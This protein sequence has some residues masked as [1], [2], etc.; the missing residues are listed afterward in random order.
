MKLRPLGDR[1]VIK[2]VEAEE[3]TKSVSFFQAVLKSNLKWQKL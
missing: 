3:K 1:V 2:L